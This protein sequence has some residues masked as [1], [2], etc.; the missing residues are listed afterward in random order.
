MT[1]AEL[2]I[3]L[4]KLPPD[5]PVRVVLDRVLVSVDN[6]SESWMDLDDD[7]AQGADDV[8]HMGSHVLIRGR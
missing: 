4:S 2:F 5:L 3:A 1:V 6:N 8:R 7:D